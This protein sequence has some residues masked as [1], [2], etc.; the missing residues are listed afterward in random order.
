[1]TELLNAIDLRRSRRKY[2]PA[3]MKDADVDVLWQWSG[4]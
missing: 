3:L 1:M 2:L 4:V